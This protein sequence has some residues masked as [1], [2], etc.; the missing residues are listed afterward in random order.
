[1]PTVTITHII[2]ITAL[3]QKSRSRKLSPAKI[4]VEYIRPKIPYSTTN[5]YNGPKFRNIKLSVTNHR[6]LV[7]PRKPQNGFKLRLLLENCTKSC[8]TNLTLILYNSILYE[9]KT[10]R[11][12]FSSKLITI[13]KTSTQ[14]TRRGC[15]YTLKRLCETFPSFIY[16]GFFKTNIRPSFNFV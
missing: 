16:T 6:P 7:L 4:Y 9:L 10:Q 15:V 12:K 1:M 2:N 14:V 5:G 13:P 3:G 11:Y 8:R